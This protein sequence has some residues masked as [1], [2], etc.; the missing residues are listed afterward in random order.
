MGKLPMQRQSLI[1][2]KRVH[3]CSAE[4]GM[5][6]V[7]RSL[8]NRPSLEIRGGDILTEGGLGGGWG[9]E[10]KAGL[11]MKGLHFVVSRFFSKNFK[12]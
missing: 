5:A 11:A 9:R 1:W 8:S 10:V 7:F 2:L 12:H 6:M 4:H 3:V